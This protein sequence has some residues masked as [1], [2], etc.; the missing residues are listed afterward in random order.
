MLH[1]WDCAIVI[2]VGAH[3][4]HAHPAIRSC[5]KVTSAAYFPDYNEE[6]NILCTKRFAASNMQYPSTVSSGGVV[7]MKEPI[8]SE[9]DSSPPGTRPTKNGLK[10]TDPSCTPTT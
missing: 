2:V 3:S 5:R 1:E 7:N 6:K 9:E 8:N 4:P 10:S